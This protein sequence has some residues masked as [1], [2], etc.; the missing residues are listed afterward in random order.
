MKT[1]KLVTPLILAFSQLLLQHSVGAVDII[2]HQMDA[3][4]SINDVTGMQNQSE[5]KGGA[6]KI[7]IQKRP[8]PKVLA[9]INGPG[10]GIMLDQSGMS[11][12]IK[13]REL[14]RNDQ[15]RAYYGTLY[16]G[17]PPQA[18]SCIFD[19]GSANAWIASKHAKADLSKQDDPL[20]N[21]DKSETFIEPE[22]K[23]WTKIDFGSGSLRGYFAQDSV[24]LGDLS[25][26]S[27]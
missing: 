10:D 25:V 5:Q 4:V 18:V 26:E 16:M 11:H 17:T 8:A 6:I 23:Q 15:N 7:P 13:V 24:M 2:K 3:S 14:L 19:T 20:F 12:G 21:E 1:T 27:A 9:N 22:N